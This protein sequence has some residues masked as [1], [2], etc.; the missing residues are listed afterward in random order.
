MCGEDWIEDLLMKS[1]N[2]VEKPP[3]RQRKKGEAAASIF[4]G[5]GS[6]HLSTVRLE[7][8]QEALLNPRSRVRSYP[9]Q[10]RIQPSHLGG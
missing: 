3:R 9:Q 5:S 1:R 6:R 8:H 2:G 7:P 10:Q 4:Y